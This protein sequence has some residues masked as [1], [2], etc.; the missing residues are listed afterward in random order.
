MAILQ[1]FYS[2]RE[3]V[4]GLNFIQELVVR[5]RHCSKWVG[6]QAFAFICQ[7]STA[8]GVCPLLVGCTSLECQP[9]TWGSVDWT[10]HLT[11]DCDNSVRQSDSPTVTRPVHMFVLGIL[12]ECLLCARP[13]LDA[14][15][16]EWT[17]FC[18]P[19]TFHLARRGPGPE[20]CSCPVQPRAVLLTTPPL[21]QLPWR[22]GGLKSRAGG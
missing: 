13:T 4:L 17:R 9:V 1:K 21:S 12:I 7:V 3:N 11:G 2:N 16:R 5:F 14:G 20:P 22:E 15:D 19:S 10:P 8:W 6:R 18:S